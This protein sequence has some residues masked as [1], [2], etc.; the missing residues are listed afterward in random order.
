MECNTIMD[1]IHYLEGEI[2][3][4]KNEVDRLNFIIENMQVDNKT[5]NLSIPLLN[6]NFCESK[7]DNNQY[8]NDSHECL[9]C[10]S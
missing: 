2:E 10:G 9:M 4:L 1:R 6:A 3:L 7:Y 5:T 8:D